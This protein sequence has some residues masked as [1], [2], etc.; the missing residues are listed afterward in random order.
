MDLSRSVGW[1]TTAYP[2]HLHPGEDAGAAIR[3]VKEQLR[4]VPGNGLGYGVLRHLGD[5]EA[6]ATL[7]ALP[8]ARVTFNYLGQFDGSFD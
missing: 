7:R 2:V 5:G 1:F 8:E 6:Q 3:A 4:A